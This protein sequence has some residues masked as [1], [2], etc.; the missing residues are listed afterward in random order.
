MKSSLCRRVLVTVVGISAIVVSVSHQCA[1]SQVPQPGTFPGPSDNVLD[2]NEQILQ[3]DLN[4]ELGIPGRVLRMHYT[5]VAPHGVIGQ[6]SHANR[7]TIEFLLQGTAVETSKGKD[8]KVVVRTFSKG[9]TELSSVDI[10]HWWANKSRDMVKIMAVDIWTGN[11]SVVSRPQGNPRTEPFQAPLNPDNIKIENLG[12]LD[13][14]VQFPEIPEAQDYILRSRRFTMLPK[15]KSQ[16]DSGTGK[17]SI[18]YIVQGD[19]WENR[20]D[21]ASSIRREGEYSVASNGISYYWENT[22]TTTVILWV[23][24][25]VKKPT[26]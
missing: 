22:T 12:Y 6:H 16:M 24:D 8:E 10:T 17:P 25:V 13:L 26:Q 4:N 11:S 7:P 1:Y 14:A 20:S 19:V 21:E 3:L 2:Y 5:T 9:E 15:Q 23:V 18:T